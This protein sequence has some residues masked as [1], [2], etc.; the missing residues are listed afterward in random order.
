MSISRDT[1]KPLHTRTLSGA[2]TGPTRGRERGEGVTLIGTNTITA[3]TETETAT[4][5]TQQE[6]EEGDDE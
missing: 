2:S 6:D 1:G 4:T 3:E 5:T